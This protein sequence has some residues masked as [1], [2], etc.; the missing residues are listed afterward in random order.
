LETDCKELFV[1]GGGE[2]YQQSMA[3]AYRIYLTRVHT[4]VEGDA[5]FPVVDEALWRLTSN[6]DFP[7]DDKHAYAYSFQLWERKKNS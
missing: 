2:I 1:I 7:A 3:I 5:F 4:M 6:L